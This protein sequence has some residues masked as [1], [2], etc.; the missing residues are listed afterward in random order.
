MGVWGP[1][2][3]TMIVGGFIHLAIASYYYGKLSQKVADNTIRLANLELTVN[4]HE[5]ILSGIVAVDHFKQKQQGA[6]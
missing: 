5:Q 4:R 6:H 3:L 2:A 1:V